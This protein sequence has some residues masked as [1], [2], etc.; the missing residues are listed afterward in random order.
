MLMLNY[1]YGVDIIVAHTFVEAFSAI[2]RYK[3]SEKIR[4]TVVV[5]NRRIQNRSALLALNQD[6]HFPLI[7]VL[8]SHQLEEQQN[9]RHSSSSC[10]ASTTSSSAPGRWR[11]T[12]ATRRPS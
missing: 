5:Q 8:P 1:R 9:T 6:D 7:L 11:P 4:C 12:A 3:E 2:Q 10:S